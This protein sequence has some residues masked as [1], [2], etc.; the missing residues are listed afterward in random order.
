MS[1]LKSIKLKLFPFFNHYS[2]W[3][4]IIFIAFFLRIYGLNLNPVGI[5]HDDELHEILNAKSL[6]LTGSH[7][8]GTVAGIFTPNNH[9]PGNCV[10]GELGSYILIPWMWIFPLDLFW[11]KIPFVLASVGIAFY[12][13]KLFQNFSGN[14]KIGLLTGLVIAI[15]PWSIHFGRTAY[16]TIFSYLFYILGVYF[17]TRNKSF[18]TNLIL[19]TFYSIVGSMFYFG[20]KPIFP[21]IVIWG[22]LY[23]PLSLKLRNLKFTS[24]LL[25]ITI[26][27]I[28]L[29]FILLSNSYA[30]RRLG[31]ISSTNSSISIT[32][33]VNLQ[34]HES[35]E[36]PMIRDLLIN[37]FSVNINARIESILGSFSPSF[38]FLRS[39]GS[40]D[41]YYDSNHSYYYLLDLFFFIFG[42]LAL[43]FNFRKSLFILSLILIA[44]F[45]AAIKTTGDTIYALRIGLVYPLMSG[46]IA[47]GIYFV[48]KNI[49]SY[50]FKPFGSL[51]L[52]K[53]FIFLIAFSYILCL[54]NY[55]SMYWF[56]N[57]IDKNIGWY[58]HKR[59]LSNYIT[60]LINNTDKNAIIVTAQPADTFNTYIFFSRKYNDKSNIIEI[61]KIYESGDYKYNG[62]KFVSSCTQVSANDLIESTIFI[63]QTINCSLNQNKTNKIANPKDGGGMYN[64][65]NDSL[66]NNSKLNRYP[67]PRKID[68]FNI[69]TMDL[70]T[71]CN[72]WITNPDQHI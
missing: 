42:M 44:V 27:L 25:I 47:W 21:L 13:G 26:A 16:L 3:F 66:C 28:F 10:Y 49:A 46:L 22:I 18:K 29:Y 12:T 55:M 43:A 37:K 1:F 20:T 9:C 24:L 72:T 23:N 39:T 41:I 5:S 33:E 36:I 2:L 14:Y 11:S 15:N 30:G 54:I 68:Q 31:E 61:N 51:T 62:V 58:F 57:P 50:K 4:L 64:I 63:E 38:L 19:G 56:R 32:E 45:P 7:K 53:L 35:L 69:E 6:A 17:Y 52:S 48:Y 40:T 70:K 8:P 34:R 59:I 60:R 71:F 65:I 67:Y